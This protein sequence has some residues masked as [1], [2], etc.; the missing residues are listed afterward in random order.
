MKFLLKR[1]TMEETIEQEK[2]ESKELGKLF[3]ALAKAQLEI[4]AAKTSSSNPF[5]KSKYADLAEI[6]KASRESLAKNALSIVQRV[7]PTGEGKMIL[8]TRLGHSSGQWIESGI[9]IKLDKPGIQNFGSH[10]TYL[11]R[12]MYAAIVGVVATG[13]DDDGEKAMEGVRKG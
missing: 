9:P 4:Q 3:E 6:V 12:Y 1:G 7:L 2:H 11:R 5:F 10:L 13:E 8:Y